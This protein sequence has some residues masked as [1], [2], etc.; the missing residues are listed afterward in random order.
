MP[1]GSRQAG[2]LR[3]GSRQ[4]GACARFQA[5]GPAPG[6]RQAGCLEAARPGIPNARS[7]SSGQA[8]QPGMIGKVADIGEIGQRPPVRVHVE[9]LPHVNAVLSGFQGGLP[10]GPI[11]RPGGTCCPRSA[12]GRGPVAPAN[13][14][15]HRQAHVAGQ[16]ICGCRVARRQEVSRRFPETGGPRAAAASGLAAR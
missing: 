15:H 5:G 13:H 12:A 14:E 11:P 1:A 7:A 3:H 6:S 9:Q 2:R 10:H 4:A 8:V 16:V